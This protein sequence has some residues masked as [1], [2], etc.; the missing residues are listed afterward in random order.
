MLLAWTPTGLAL[1]FFL[2]LTWVRSVAK[3]KKNKAEGENSTRRNP[4]FCFPSVLKFE[5]PFF[6]AH[7]LRIPYHEKEIL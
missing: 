3:T 4:L 7:V 2:A 5:A 6:G 1:A